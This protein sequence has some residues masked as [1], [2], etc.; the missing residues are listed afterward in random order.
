MNRCLLSSLL[1]LATALAA[2][3]SNPAP[4]KVVLP[5]GQTIEPAYILE[6]TLD[7]IKYAMGKADGPMTEVKRGRYKAAEYGDPDDRNYYAGQ[8]AFGRK[9]FDKAIGPLQIALANAKYYWVRE[10]AH[11]LLI[12]AQL[13]AGKAEDAIAEVGRYEKAYPRGLRLPQA[14]ALKGQAELK[15]GDAAA[16]AKTFA[17]LSAKA[18]DWGPLAAALGARGQANA[19]AADKKFAEAAKVLAPVFAAIDP[20]K[21]EQLAAEVGFALGEQYGLAG[22]LAPATAVYRR[23]AYSAAGTEVQARAH[24]GWARLTADKPETAGLVQAFDHAAI[25][26]LLRGADEATANAA[27]DLARRIADR[28]QKQADVSDNDKRDYRTYRF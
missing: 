1:L 19:L 26:A 5:N 24:L 18:G 9:E 23:L 21:D 10:A 11:L 17:A 14:Y 6:E 13:Q 25:A 20:A 12:D 16:A 28:L 2:G 8:G 3:E 7:G 15:K 4:G 27:V 22:E